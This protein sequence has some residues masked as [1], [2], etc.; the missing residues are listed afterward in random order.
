MNWCG[1]EFS[2]T[3]L[4]QAWLVL[5][6]VEDHTVEV[7]EGAPEIASTCGAGWFGDLATSG[8]SS[9]YQYVP[10]ILLAIPNP[11]TRRRV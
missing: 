6:S 4:H 10:C 11:L 7:L 2:F 1:A 3:A 5:D 8:R 9:Q